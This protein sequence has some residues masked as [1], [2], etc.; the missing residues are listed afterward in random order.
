VQQAKNEEAAEKELLLAE[1]KRAR[2]ATADAL[3]QVRVRLYS[4]VLLAGGGG[5]PRM[6]QAQRS[7][8]LETGKRLLCSGLKMRTRLKGAAAGYLHIAS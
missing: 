4:M 1:L 3:R 7:A 5:F 6:L 2:K 8:Y